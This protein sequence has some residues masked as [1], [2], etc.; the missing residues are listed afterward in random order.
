SAVACA[1]LFAAIACA[2]AV[3]APKATSA[4]SHKARRPAPVPQGFVGM[5]LSEPFFDP[6]VDQSA[7]FD[8]MVSAGVQ[9]VRVVFSWA[10]AQPTDGGPISFDATDQVVE[11]AASRGLRVLPVVLYTPEWDAASHS[12]GTTAI[13]ADDGPYAD[14]VKALV[15]RYRPRGG[16]SP[17]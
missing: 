3:A 9:S 15:L 17:A 10:E 1:L 2:L 12:D 11:Q 4:R 14:Y 6:R 8:T 7:Q 13:P 16:L 5:N